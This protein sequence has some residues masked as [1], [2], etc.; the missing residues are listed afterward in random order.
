MDTSTLRLNGHIIHKTDDRLVKVMYSST[1]DGIR[2][3]VW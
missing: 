3:T 1:A 2:C